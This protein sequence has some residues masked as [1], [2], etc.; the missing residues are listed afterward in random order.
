MFSRV[1][2][3]GPWLLVH[4]SHGSSYEPS[5]VHSKDHGLGVTVEGQDL[6]NK[7]LG[8]WSLT[9]IKSMI[10]VMRKEQLMRSVT[11]VKACYSI[12]MKTPEKWTH[13]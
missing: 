9:I 7:V 6:T 10:L 8:F 2:R 12:V 1:R 13:F 3:A 4:H 11:V 5:R